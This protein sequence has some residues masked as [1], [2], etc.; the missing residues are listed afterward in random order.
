[1][2]NLLLGIL[3]TFALVV[4]FFLINPKFEAKRGALNSVWNTLR[5]APAHQAVV[6]EGG[7]L[8]FQ[9]QYNLRVISRATEYIGTLGTGTSIYREIARIAAEDNQENIRY[10][11]VLD[12]AVRSTSESGHILE[13]ARSVS[14][15]DSPEDEAMWQEAYDQMLLRAEYPSVEIAIERQKMH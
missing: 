12:L 5:K 14:R 6:I 7:G 13:L 8:A 11:A 9:A 3:F 1:M 10:E 4:L 2:K 15:I